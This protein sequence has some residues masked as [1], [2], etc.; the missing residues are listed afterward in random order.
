M[1]KQKTQPFGASPMPEL[2]A[3]VNAR[4]HG[5]YATRGH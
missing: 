2:L 5:R 1:R 4:I 3:D